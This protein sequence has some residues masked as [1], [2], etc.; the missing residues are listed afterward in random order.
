MP[1]QL[2]LAKLVLKLEDLVLQPLDLCLVS[3]SA[4]EDEVLEDSEVFVDLVE[5]V[6]LNL[7]VIILDVAPAGLLTLLHLEGRH[8][9]SEEAQTRCVASA[10]LE[11]CDL[12]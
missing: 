12:L 11:A 3:L 6:D 9:A 5:V 4:L 7:V 1:V 8:V 2:P 10:A